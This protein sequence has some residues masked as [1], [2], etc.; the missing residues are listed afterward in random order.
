MDEFKRTGI[1][2]ALQAAMGDVMAIFGIGM[3]IMAFFPWNIGL[4]LRG[5]VFFA[6][7]LGY[8]YLAIERIINLK[9]NIIHNSLAAEKGN[10]LNR[11]DVISIIF[12]LMGNI[13]FY[14]GVILLGLAAFKYLAFRNLPLEYLDISLALEAAGLTSISVGVLYKI[15]NKFDNIYEGICEMSK[16]LKEIEKRG[17]IIDRRLN[18]TTRRIK[19]QKY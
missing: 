14:V 11:F 13:L 17:Q 6:L 9:L 10:K 16:D 19:K 3:F 1:E 2:S 18:R 8:R 7:A 4:L 15:N 5:I 12:K